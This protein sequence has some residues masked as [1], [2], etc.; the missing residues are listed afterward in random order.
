MNPET[1]D[2]ARAAKRASSGWATG[3]TC[4]IRAGRVIAA[5]RPQRGS[6][7]LESLAL[8]SG[9]AMQGDVFVFAC[10]PWLPQVFP[11]LLGERLFITRQDVVYLGPPAGDVRFA[12]PAM[13]VWIDF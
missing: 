13:P 4:S 6:G 2:R 9:D 1:A 12:S 8:E 10:G 7:R 11:D 3:R 5:V